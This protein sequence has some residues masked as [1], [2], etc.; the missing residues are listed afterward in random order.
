[1]PNAQQRSG[2]A[3]KAII[4]QVLMICALLLSPKPSAAQ[5]SQIDGIWR[6]MEIDAF[7]EILSTEGIRDGL[8]LEDGMF[9]GE[10]G[11]E[12]QDRVSAIF[13]PAVMG[14]EFKAALSRS[15]QGR[16]IQS[17]IDFFDT[18]LGRRSIEL[19][20][21]A[22]EALLDPDLEEATRTLYRQL[23][24]RGDVRLDL[25]GGYSDANDLVNFNVS[26]TMNAQY[27][28]LAALADEGQGPYAD[29]PSALVNEIWSQ[30]PEIRAESEEWVMSYYTFVFDPLT[31][32]ELNALIAFSETPAAR[33]VNSALFAAF[34]RVFNDVARQLGKA[35]ADMMRGE[36]L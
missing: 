32:D 25:I 21:S 3:P 8:E 34:D 14:A 1:M 26:G 35:V 27:A 36:R 9:P 22:R 33:H 17:A 23:R 24:D 5:D 7:I 10:G 29:D 30:E 31:E 18:G 19:E 28:F 16:D 15:L 4:V 2:M 6:A 11:R 20:L 12:W 13:A